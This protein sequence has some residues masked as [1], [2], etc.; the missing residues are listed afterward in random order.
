MYEFHG[1]IGL[2][3]STEDIDAGNLETLLTE[4][5]AILDNIEWQ[6]ASLQFEYLNGQPFLRMGGLINRMRDEATDVDAIYSFVA[7]RL[8]GSW[9]L[10]YERADDMPVPPGP[11][12][13]KVRVLA[14]GKLR[15]HLDPFLSPC[16]PNIE[17]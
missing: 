14:R 17:D 10:L 3:E 7:N 15:S 13:F 8:P 9:G 4:L 16:K 11:G 5:R 12:A 6:T 2:A 1:W